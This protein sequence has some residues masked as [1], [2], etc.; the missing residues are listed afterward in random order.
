[1][2]VMN[3]SSQRLHN[4][5]ADLR[6]HESSARK[7]ASNR[8][9]LGVGRI[10]TLEDAPVGV[11]VRKAWPLVA[12]FVRGNRVVAHAN[13]RVTNGAVSVGYNEHPELGLSIVQLAKEMGGIVLERWPL[14]NRE[15]LVSDAELDFVEGFGRDPAN[16]TAMCKFIGEL[17][18]P[19]TV[20]DIAY[21]P[22]NIAAA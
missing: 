21:L 12:D 7:E 15:Q 18:Q 2:S 8:Q 20:L 11:Y 9:F 3:T 6:T 1:M 10:V 13:Y 5:G 22:A 17:G 4:L 16:S 14:N 19:I